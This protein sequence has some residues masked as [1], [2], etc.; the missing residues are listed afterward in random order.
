[1]SRKASGTSTCLARANWYPATPPTRP[2]FAAFYESIEARA[3][4]TYAGPMSVGPEMVAKAIEHAVSS[5]RPRSRYPLTPGARVMIA[6]R[7]VLPDGGW[8]ALMG[9]QFVRP[10]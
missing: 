1:M 3:R 2:E 10:K 9:M 6:A 8:D 7:R 4:G 5:S